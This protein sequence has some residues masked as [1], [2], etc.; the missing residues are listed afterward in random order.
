MRS[1]SNAEFAAVLVEYE[2]GTYLLWMK[3]K[4]DLTLVMIRKQGLEQNSG[5]QAQSCQ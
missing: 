4:N 1:S 5:I 2:S 3:E